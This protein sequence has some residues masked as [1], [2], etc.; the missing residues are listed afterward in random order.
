MRPEYYYFSNT[1]IHFFM[2]YSQLRNSE[3]KTGSEFL[4]LLTTYDENKS[5]IDFNSFKAVYYKNGL[6]LFSESEIELY[7]FV[8]DTENIC[9]KSLFEDNILQI[10]EKYFR[11]YIKLDGSYPLSNS[12]IHI[13]GTSSYIVNPF[14]YT[15]NEFIKYIINT[16]PDPKRDN[17]RN[18]KLFLNTVD[19][20]GHLQHSNFSKTNY[21][22]VKDNFI[23]VKEII[24]KN[25]KPI[26]KIENKTFYEYTEEKSV[27]LLSNYIGF[28]KYENYLTESQKKVVYSDSLGPIRLT[29][30]AGSG[31]TL[32]LIL[33]AL[34]LAKKYE[35][36]KKTLRLAFICH[37]EAM[38][39]Y[40]YDVLSFDGSTYLDP[41]NPVSISVV[42][43]LEWCCTYAIKDFSINDCLEVDSSDTKIMQEMLLNNSFKK[44]MEKEFSLF[45]EYLS[46]DFIKFLNDENDAKIVDLLKNEI[47]IYI[48]GPN[49]ESFEAYY[50]SSRINKLIPLRNR[51]DYAAIFKIYDIYQQSL[52]DMGKYDIDDVSSV[53]LGFLTRAIWKRNRSLNG[54]DSIFVD[55]LHLY[56]FS[57]ISILR[58]ML[59]EHDSNH[60][61]SASDVSQSSSDLDIITANIN[62]ISSNSESENIFNVIF[63]SSQSIINLTKYLFINNISLF[64]NQNPLKNASV[65]QNEEGDNP[66]VIRSLNDSDLMKKL[67]NESFIKNHD[68]ANTLVICTDFQQKDLFLAMLDKQKISYIDIKRRNDLTSIKKAKKEC[69]L[70]VGYIDFIGGLEFDNVCILGFDIDKVPPFDNSMSSEFLKHIWYRK[71]YVA[72]TRAKKKLYIYSNEIN[73]RHPFINSALEQNLIQDE[74]KE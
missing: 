20:T 58:Y 73:G 70:V 5:V 36:E 56:D 41:E 12:E 53:S 23:N 71:I 50:E 22:K 1:F 24:N 38:K 51:E 55:E 9:N 26:E 25:I 43:L 7:G 14:T 62:S 46:K 61:I 30:P 21:K 63:R 52:T 48:K 59:K 44:F 68:K 65:L 27:D 11:I 34:Y 47:S 13:S 57:E 64:I 72:F 35:K 69:K 54:Y 37:S 6:Y 19:G 45:K 67:L 18:V 28:S 49:I 74:I 3:F 17:S 66:K 29:G 10:I 42:T 39:E 8:L 33:K 2:K 32:S 16:T 40:I 31:K 60:I 4:K 15:N